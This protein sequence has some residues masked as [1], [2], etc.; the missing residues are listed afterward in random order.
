MKKFMILTLTC[1][2][3]VG[4]PVVTISANASTLDDIINEQQTV[5]ATV[6]STPVTTESAT[7]TTT[8]S[9][10]Q[11]SIKQSNQEYINSLREA[12]TL[13]GESEAATKVNQG[14]KKVASFIIQVLSYVIVLF[15]VVRVVVDLCYILIPFTRSFLGN[16]FQG[17]APSGG[18][19][20]GMNG[21]GI[22]GIGGIGAMNG[23]SSGY[24]MNRYSGGI[25]GYGSSMN[26][27]NVGQQGA[28]QPAGRTQWVSNAAL[29][30]VAAQSVVGPDG[31]PASPLKIYAKDMIVVL[32]VTPILLTLAITGVLTDLGF[33][34]GQLLANAISGISGMV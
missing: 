1:L 21:G 17:T 28:Q 8:S 24:G 14:I 34:L 11:D 10:T 20:P 7:T 16:G 25:G 3:T 6:D 2:L 9:S 22:G 29:N 23:Y 27:M 30:A 5:E 12:T 32:V 18:Q 15:L 13:D 26:S 4:A 19:Q 31:K 33:L